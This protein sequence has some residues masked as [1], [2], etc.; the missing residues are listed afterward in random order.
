MDIFNEFYKKEKPFLL[1]SL[2]VSVLVV[3]VVV[4]AVLQLWAPPVETLIIPTTATKYTLL[5]LVTYRNNWQAHFATVFI[6]GGGGGVDQ[7][8]V[9]EVVPDLYALCPECTFNYTS[10]SNSWKWW[11]D[12]LVPQSYC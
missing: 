4:V 12:L 5:H 11:Q 3:L 6:V 8:E 9:V 7:V 2:E 1:E 10:I